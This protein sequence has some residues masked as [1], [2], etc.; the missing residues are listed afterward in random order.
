VKDLAAARRYAR[1]VVEA[2]RE[3]A[4]QDRVLE[5]MRGVEVLLR[6]ERML[7][8]YLTDVRVKPARRMEILRALS[9]RAGLAPETLHVLESVARHGRFEIFAEIVAA[10]SREMDRVRGVLRVRI[11]S[12]R[13]MDGEQVRRVEDALSRKTGRRV[14]AE[15]ETDAALLGGLSLQAG[16]VVYDASLKTLIERAA[17]RWAA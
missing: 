3:P 5:E 12:A 15:A 13:P 17:A 11:R 2:V 1:A 10:L 6:S 4:A 14:A 9:A 8:V 16:S 7:R